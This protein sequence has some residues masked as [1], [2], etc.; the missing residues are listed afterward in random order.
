[1]TTN[2]GAAGEAA[3]FV[4]P[5]E[6]QEA[7]LRVGLVGCGGRGRGAI[8][9]V[10]EAAPNVQVTALADMFP[11]RVATTMKLGKE[12]PGFKV[13][14]EACFTGF[15]AVKRLLDANVDYV[16]LCQ[17]PGFRP[18]HFELAIEAGKHVFM[19]K[20][21]AVDPAGVRKVI[22]AG[23]K[24]RA[25]KLGVIPGTQ[26]RHS[27]KLRETVRRIH[28]GQIGEVVAGRIYFNT[29]YLWEVERQEG[30]SDLEWQIRNWYYFDWLSGDHIVEQHVHQ[31][32]ATDWVL[33]SHP[34][35]A[36]GVGGRQVRIEPLYGNIYDHF[37]VDYEYPNDIH[38]FSMCRQWKGT[39]GKVEAWFTGTQGEACLAGP[40]SGRITGKDP[41]KFEGEDPK[42]Q[43]QEHRDLIESIRAGKPLNDARR[44]AETTLSAILGREAAYTGKRIG[45][46][47]LLASD[48]DLTPP[49][50]EFGPHEARPVRRP[51]KS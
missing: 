37:A 20:P 16:M 13:A 15:D 5:R 34:V 1:M 22:A 17:P 25:K 6:P 45:W 2:G 12:M 48:L 14:D 4:F 51:G 26:S 29:G 18:A 30:M 8:E 7:T 3:P 31:I 50:L 43:V 32:D 23:E 11:D 47:E 24:A 46:D 36:V 39:P 41:W 21:V 35:A 10:L 38:V 33:K 27:A 40:V 44:I 9:N 28:Q 19:E 42:P 49:K